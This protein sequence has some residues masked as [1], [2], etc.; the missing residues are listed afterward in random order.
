MGSRQVG[1]KARTLDAS[2]PHCTKAT[3]L[4]DKEAKRRDGRRRNALRPNELQTARRDRAMSPSIER[5]R[6]FR[7]R[8]G[9]DP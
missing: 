6:A 5:T 1:R 3:A 8:S 9:R 4:D 2:A 7:T